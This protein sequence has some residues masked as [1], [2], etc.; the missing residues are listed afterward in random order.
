MISIPFLLAVTVAAQ[1]YG[2]PYAWLPAAGLICE[3]LYRPFD[4]WARGDRLG[5]NAVASAFLRMILSIA[6]AIGSV[7]FWASLGLCGY[8]IWLG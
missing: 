6:G 2:L 1:W 4:G 7:S 8:W 3:V 5:Q